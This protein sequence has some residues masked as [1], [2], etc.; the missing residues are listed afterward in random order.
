M[1]KV[2]RNSLPHLSRLNLESAI[3]VAY[4]SELSSGCLLVIAIRHTLRSMS[5]LV[6]KLT[7]ARGKLISALLGIY[8]VEARVQNVHA[9]S[10]R[11]DLARV[12]V[13][14]MSLVVDLFAGGGGA[15]VGLTPPGNVIGPPRTADLPITRAPRRAHAERVDGGSN[16]FSTIALNPPKIIRLPSKGMVFSNDFMRGSFMTSLFTRSR[17]LR[18][19]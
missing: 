13:V 5:Q 6:R 16:Y 11:N 14:S 8:V 17:S 15:S 1:R 4:G 2:I 19:L 9:G 10:K 3:L 7:E 12:E 18:D